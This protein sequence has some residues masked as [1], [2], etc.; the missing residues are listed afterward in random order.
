MAIRTS[1]LLVKAADDPMQALATLLKHVEIREDAGKLVLQHRT[2]AAKLTIGDT[3]IK[4]SAPSI[5]LQA[6]GTLSI[7]GNDVRARSAVKLSLDAGTDLYFH[8]AAQ[9]T[10][11]CSGRLELDAGSSARL[12]SALTEV[13]ASMVKCA[14][15]VKTDTLIA[16]SVVA[17]SYT[18]GVGNIT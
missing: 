13:N 4:L 6:T 1:R 18:P 9:A 3:G 14:S 8:A 15:I 7:E 5:D 16:N 2:S 17:S 12:T 10:V 11:A